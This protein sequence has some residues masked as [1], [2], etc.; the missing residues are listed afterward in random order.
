LS[1]GRF[2][3]QAVSLQHFTAKSR[4]RSIFNI[5]EVCSEKSSIGRGFSPSPS[6]LLF[7]IIEKVLHTY[8]L[9]KVAVTRK[10]NWRSVGT[11]QK[12]IF[13]RKS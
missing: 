12:A 2:I 5:C 13:L 1:P 11:S 3:L 8:L 10:K 4:V 9:L 6:V 7:C